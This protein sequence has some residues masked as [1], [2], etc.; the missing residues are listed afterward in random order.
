MQASLAEPDASAIPDE[1]FETVLSF[2]SEG[3]GCAVAGAATEGVLYL[4]GEAIDAGSHVDG[5]DDQPDFGGCE[6]HGSCRNRSI[7]QEAL[8]GGSSTFQPPGL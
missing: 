4:M 1:Q 8:L 7:S 5:F 3:I 6:V 2:V